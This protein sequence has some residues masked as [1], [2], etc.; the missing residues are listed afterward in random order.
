MVVVLAYKFRGYYVMTGGSIDGFRR[1]HQLLLR[2]ICTKGPSVKTNFDCR[3]II[4]VGGV[5]VQ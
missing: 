4:L 1:S 3:T 5:E 2:K